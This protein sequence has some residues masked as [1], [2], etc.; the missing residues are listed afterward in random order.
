[1]R[2]IRHVIVDD[3]A[4]AVWGEAGVIKRLETIDVVVV[5]PC[6][7]ATV[8]PT[9]SLTNRANTSARRNT[10]ILRLS[11]S[12]SSGLSRGW[13]MNKPRIDILHNIAGPMPIEIHTPFPNPRVSSLSFQIRTADSMPLVQ[14]QRS[15]CP[16]PMP[17]YRSD[18]NVCSKPSVTRPTAR[19]R[20]FEISLLFSLR[21]LLLKNLKIAY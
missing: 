11:D 5:L 13:R 7:P 16:M 17:P 12:I 15:Q 20:P 8:I 3:P 14:K 2:V 4:M 1:M 21:C 9:W 10:R 18:D 19:P 6:A